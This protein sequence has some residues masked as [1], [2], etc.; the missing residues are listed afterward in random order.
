[1]SAWLAEVAP[2]DAGATLTALI[3][4]YPSLAS[5][6]AAIASAAP[7]LWDLVRADPARAVR[8]L[9]HDPHATLA[10]LLGTAR[11]AAAAARGPGELM[12]SLR[13][14]KAEAALL[15]ALADIGNV[16][17]VARITQALTDIADAT[18]GAAVRH[19]LDEAA[20]R[21]RLVPPDAAPSGCRLRLYR[22]GDGQDGRP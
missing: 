20:R 9:R 1:M 8:I 7:Y 2:S 18:L 19:V 5:V 17:P 21:G 6:L 14:I 10:A 11:H 12:A 15:I 3:E 22:A 13:A 4:E 16:W